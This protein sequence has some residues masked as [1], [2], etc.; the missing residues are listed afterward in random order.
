MWAEPLRY[1]CLERQFDT[2]FV[3]GYYT[4]TLPSGLI[5]V[6]LN[7]NFY[8]QS[9]KVFSDLTE[10]DPGSQFTMLESL[11]QGA[12]DNKTKVSGCFETTQMQC[13]YYISKPY[14]IVMDST[15]FAWRVFLVGIH[16]KNCDFGDR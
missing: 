8:Y 14:A 7:T 1:L 4:V 10:T 6:A 2:L 5:A 3:D 9:N 16:K 11:L 13:K 15:S 12:R